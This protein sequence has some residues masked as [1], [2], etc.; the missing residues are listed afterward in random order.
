[1]VARPALRST[2]AHFSDTSSPRRAPVGRDDLAGFLVLPRLASG[3]GFRAAGVA[4]FRDGVGCYLGDALAG[5]LLGPP[6]EL[7]RAGRALHLVELH[8]DRLRIILGER[9]EARA[10]RGGVREVTTLPEGGLDRGRPGFRL[11]PVRECR[12]LGRAALY[13]HL[14][15]IGNVLRERRDDA[16]DGSHMR[17]GALRAAVSKS[18]HGVCT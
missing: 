8:Q 11:L 2:S 13:S 15:T 10:L 1:M 5:K 7:K 16:L 4:R 14:R 12:R 6:V 17:L 3:E 18:L 9:I